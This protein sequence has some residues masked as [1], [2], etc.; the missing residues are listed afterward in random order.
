M[1]DIKKES[2]FSSVWY[3]LG[4][5][6]I[7]AAA[8]LLLAPKKGSETRDDISD[9]SRRSREKTRS[10]MTKIGDALP[11]RVKVAAGVGAVKSGSN[12]ALHEARDGAKKFLGT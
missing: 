7:G 10:L 3:L 12:E 6:A 2:S 4:G 8:G 5:V 1:E 9:W 11:T